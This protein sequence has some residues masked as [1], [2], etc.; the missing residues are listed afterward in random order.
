MLVC[1][2]AEQQIIDEKGTSC[3]Y[4]QFQ[5]YCWLAQLLREFTDIMKFPSRLDIQLFLSDQAMEIYIMFCHLSQ[6][7]IS[8]SDRLE[9]FQELGIEV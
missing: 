3:V 6:E 9:S 2:S 7:A 5:S 1:V 4:L 8:D